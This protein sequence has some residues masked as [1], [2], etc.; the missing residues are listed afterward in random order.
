[1]CENRLYFGHVNRVHT[2]NRIEVSLDLTLGVLVKKD[3]I[4]E[5]ITQATVSG[6]WQEATRC[7]VVLLGAENVHIYTDP[8]CRDGHLLGRVYVP[9]W[10]PGAPPVPMEIPPG[11]NVPCVEV[12][13]WVRWIA[14]EG[15]DARRLRT[16]LKEA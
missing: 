2:Y 12:S 9:S 6:R 16:A 1:M 13:S 5:G 7:L 3:V 8:S 11:T 15:F 4:I 10:R 14:D